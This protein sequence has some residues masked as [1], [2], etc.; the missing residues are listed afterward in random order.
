M[1]STFLVELFFVISMLVF[2]ATLY[3][4]MPISLV[5]KKV[6][7]KSKSNLTN[8]RFINKSNKSKLGDC[9]S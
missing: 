1:E 3:I 4:I 5:K 6:V 9:Y 2:M 7:T 8:T